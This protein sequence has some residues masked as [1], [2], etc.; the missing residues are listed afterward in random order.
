MRA[1]DVLWIVAAAAAVYLVARALMQAQSAL[2]TFYA[3]RLPQ[4]AA[5]DEMIGA[6]V[7]RNSR[8]ELEGVYT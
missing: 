5:W 6:Y 4:G 1:I 2:R 3:D 7:I 8:G